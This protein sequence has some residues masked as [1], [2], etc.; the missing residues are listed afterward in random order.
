M[1]KKHESKHQICPV[2]AK[3]CIGHTVSTDTGFSYKAHK[4]FKEVQ[5]CTHLY[6][7]FLHNPGQYICRRDNHICQDNYICPKCGST[8]QR[9]PDNIFVPRRKKKRPMRKLLNK[10][11]R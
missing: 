6:I 11:R 3:H 7:D 1:T 4:S 2:D 5:K 9:I 8:M 10:L